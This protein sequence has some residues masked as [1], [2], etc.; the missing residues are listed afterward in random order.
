MKLLVVVALICLSTYPCF[1]KEAEHV[2]TIS[3]D[4]DFQEAVQ[5]SEF[6]V[7]EFYAPWCG[8]CKSLAPEYE[9]A[10]KTLKDNKSAAVLAKARL[11]MLSCPDHV[12]QCRNAER[13]RALCPADSASVTCSETYIV[14]SITLCRLMRQR[15]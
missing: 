1:G 8:H 6:L 3:G 13:H 9:K 2:V 4:A 14:D 5:G 15:T 10:A 12:M 11:V 7:A